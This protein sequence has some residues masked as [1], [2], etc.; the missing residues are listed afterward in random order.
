MICVVGSRNPRLTD[1]L[2][3]L[4]KNK[5]LSMTGAEKAEGAIFFANICTFE[6]RLVKSKRQ[7]KERRSEHNDGK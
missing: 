1:K 7:I 6:F 4:R 5:S 3:T 2:L